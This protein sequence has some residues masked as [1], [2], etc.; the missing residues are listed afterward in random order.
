M[1]KSTLLLILCFQL[2]LANGQEVETLNPSSVHL[3][4]FSEKAKAE[5]AQRDTLMSKLASN[6]LKWD[7]MSKEEQVLM[8]KFGEVYEDIWD[9]V[10]GGCSWYCGGGPHK[11]SASSFLKSQG[12]ISYAPKNAHDLNYKNAWVEGSDA[13]GIGEYLEYKFTAGSPRITKIKVVNGYVKSE[14]A[15]QNNSRVKQLKVYLN[16][17]AF[18]IFNLE[19][20]IACQ[21][22][23]FEPI[24]E[25][26]DWILKFEILDVY[27]GDKYDDTAISEIYFDGIDVH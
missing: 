23:N 7:E 22:F 24:G 17:K 18:A 13:Y 9:I 16:D 20:K 25:K 2:I 5:W 19:D 1:K 11:V 14:T 12:K 6:R 3:L 10:G 21:S 26:T 15:Y 27:K 4:D 8:E